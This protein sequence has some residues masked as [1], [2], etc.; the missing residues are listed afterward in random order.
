MAGIDKNDCGALIALRHMEQK[1]MIVY[2]IKT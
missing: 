1:G 2:E